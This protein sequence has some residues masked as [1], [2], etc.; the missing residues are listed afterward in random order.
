MIIVPTYFIFFLIKLLTIILYI[1]IYMKII[2][3]Y[4][5]I[6]YFLIKLVTIIIYIYIY[7]W[8]ITNSWINNIRPL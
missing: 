3:S 7:G 6:L 4:K 8:S 1:Y 2:N 5:L